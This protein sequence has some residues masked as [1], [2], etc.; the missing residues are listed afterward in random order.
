MLSAS[1][2]KGQSKAVKLRLTEHGNYISNFG[3][4]PIYLIGK[5]GLEINCPFR[6]FAWAN[7]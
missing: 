5:S 6:F 1:E 2:K 3:H 4:R 7:R